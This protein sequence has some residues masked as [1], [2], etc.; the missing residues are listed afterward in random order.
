LP[1][2]PSRHA[3]SHAGFEAAAFA[4]CASAGKAIAANEITQADPQI[5]AE[6]TNERAANHRTVF[7]FI[8]LLEIP[9]DRLNA[10]R[11]SL[12]LRGHI[13]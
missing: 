12:I 1:A 13:F 4:A 5:A 10:T 3:R 6:I 8:P 7:K 2:I 11:Q 9:L